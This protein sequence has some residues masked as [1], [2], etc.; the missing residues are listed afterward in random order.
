MLVCLI[1]I[2]TKYYQY[3]HE[4]F[5][6][7]PEYIVSKSLYHIVV[8]FNS[9]SR[10]EYQNV[11][12]FLINLCHTEILSVDEDWESLYI[13]FDSTTVSKLQELIEQEDKVLI[14]NSSSIDRTL[15]V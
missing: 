4:V 8:A 2:I 12:N 10:I 7:K 3:Y 1:K 14:S 6:I 11:Y 5:K 13:N 15:Q 9:K